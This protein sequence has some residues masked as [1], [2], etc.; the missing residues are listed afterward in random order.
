MAAAAASLVLEGQG[1]L[2]VP[3]R[4]AVRERMTAAR[5]ARVT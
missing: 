4:D 3:D 1:L 2:G 5:R